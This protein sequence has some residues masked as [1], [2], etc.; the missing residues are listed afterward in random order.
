MPETITESQY[1]ELMEAINRNPERFVYLME[2]YTGITAKPYAAYQF[3]DPAGD[4]LGDYGYSS[5]VEILEDAGIE[6][7]EDGE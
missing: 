5:L 7:A 3:F 6:V 1:D 2:E 4:Y